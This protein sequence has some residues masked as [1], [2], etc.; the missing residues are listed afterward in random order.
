ME[1]LETYILHRGQPL[2]QE[3][4]DRLKALRDLPDNK[5]VFDEDCPELTDEQL[6]QMTRRNARIRKTA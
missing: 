2:T 1:E 5:I 3:Q 6:A 4:K